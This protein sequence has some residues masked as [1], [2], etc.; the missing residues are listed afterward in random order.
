MLEPP[1]EAVHGS[2]PSPN[3]A[4]IFWQLLASL[5]RAMAASEAPKAEPHP[6]LRVQCAHNDDGYP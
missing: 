4:C 6:L 5:L 1:L 2:A 3:G